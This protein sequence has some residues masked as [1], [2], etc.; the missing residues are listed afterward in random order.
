MTLET[1]LAPLSALEERG[2]Q[3][4]DRDWT[5]HIGGRETDAHEGR[6]FAVV[7]PYG[8][9][10]IANVPDA[11]AADVDR[12]VAACHSASPGWGR[13]TP[14]ER[15][16]HVEALA[17][18][19]EEREMDFAIVD[20][21]D[22]GAPISIMLS[23]VRMAVESLRYFAGVAMEMKGSTI[24]ASPHL[25]LTMLQP[26]G[27][28]AKI[29][30]FNHPFLFAASK[31]AA[32]LIAG[33]TVVLKPAEAT[34]LSA[35]LLGDI[36]DQVLPAGVCSI[37]VGDGPSVPTALV[38]HPLVRRI[39]FTGSER[40][41]RIIQREAADVGVKNVTLELGGKNALL[42][43]PDADL[44]AVSE[45]AIAGMN[46]TWSGQSCGSTSRL[47]LHES[48]ADDVLERISRRLSNR[49]YI[50]PLD[51]EAVQ[52]T[53]VSRRQFDRVIG[54]LDGATSRG[55]RVVTGG[56]SPAGM[57]DTLFI[58]PTYLDGVDSSWPVAR[59]EIFGPVV[60]VLRWSTEQ[61][62]ITIANDVE[63]GLTGSIFTNDTKTAMRAARD[64][65]TGYIWV[66]G[67]GVHFQGVPYGG[68]KNSGLGK[69]E[70]LEEL[71]NY[72]QSK[73]VTFFL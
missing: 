49:S 44:D 71:I 32:P 73:S 9:D 63:Y 2:R 70:S 33:N 57:E 13:M 8:E 23:D 53:M 24:P 45:A 30:P 64:L 58:E 10:V 6:T 59:E 14:R 5:L 20:S 36:L 40:V 12:A 43:F 69:E 35:L 3:L 22:S 56:G 31:I 48:I 16:L 17:D 62:A 38:R 1:A 19:I 25:H 7:A 29:I 46:F 66:N 41:G 60:S 52:G 39:G 28:V 68:W 61:E 11:G 51:P 15:A 26:Y 27:V 18:A 4:V 34:P 54:Y 37:V 65:E 21:M 42:G 55:A 67:V 47:L 72:T 50:S